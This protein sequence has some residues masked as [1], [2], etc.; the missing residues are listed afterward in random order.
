MR[1]W[2]RHVGAL[3]S[4]DAEYLPPDSGDFVGLAD[5]ALLSTMQPGS[6]A[7]IPAIGSTAIFKTAFANDLADLLRARFPIV[8]VFTFEEER[9]LKTVNEVA[10][11]LTYE[12]HVWSVVRGLV[13]KNPAGEE[14]LQTFKDSL[15]DLKIAIDQCERIA[16]DGKRHLFILLDP[17]PFLTDKPA[18]AIYR[19]RLREFAMAIRSH[20]YTASCVILSPSLDIPLELEKEITV[21]DFPVPDREQAARFVRQFVSRVATNTRIT[22]EPGDEVIEA[23]TDAAM[24]LTMAEIENC[25]AKAL[26]HDRAISRDD[27]RFMFEEKKQIIRKSGILEYIDNRSLTSADVGGLDLLKRWLQIRSLA[28]SREAK[29][30]GVDTPKGVLLTGIPGCGKSLSAKCTA[31]TWGLPLVKLDMG[32]IFSSLVGSSEEHMRTALKTCE[33]IAPCVLWID[34]IEKGLAH[35]SRS[36]GDSGVSMRVFGTLLTWMQEKT[37]PVFIFATAND[38]AALPPEMLRKG[39]FDEVFFIDL[40][41]DEERR[42]IFEVQIRRRH[43][44]P[45]KFDL[46]SLVEKSGEKHFGPDI[47]M[48]GAEIEAWVA[49]ALIESFQRTRQASPGG[50][51]EMVDF[52]VVL[53]R[54]VPLAQTRRDQLS[55]MRS[56]AAEHAVSATR[57]Q[58]TEAS[59]R[60]GGRTIHLD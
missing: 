21:V 58:K 33:A 41:N 37:A 8:Q 31:G 60:L 22:V 35:S 4:L 1:D 28:F 55:H 6:K 18:D 14:K 34:E 46:A 48:S 9:A 27:A 50:D 40:P 47:R 15:A 45:A 49:E 59:E 3:R 54:L 51:L 29:A 53:P 38:V 39:R 19:R 25:L 30:Y 10:T 2:R 36:A 56:W 26:V 44:D 52:E 43:R 20:G 23:L 7:A 5:L 17:F 32:K 24:G 57:R 12:V 11:T 42:A 13:S 16:Q